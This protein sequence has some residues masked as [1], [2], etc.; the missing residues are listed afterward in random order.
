[1]K[2][3]LE[4]SISEL[5]RRCRLGYCVSASCYCVAH[6]MFALCSGPVFF[7]DP[8]LCALDVPGVGSSN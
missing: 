5:A 3:A 6:I 8:F 4:M 2:D 1:M 7:Y